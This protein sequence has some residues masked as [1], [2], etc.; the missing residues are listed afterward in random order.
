MTIADALENLRMCTEEFETADRICQT[1]SK[2][3]G[4]A[5]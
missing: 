3:H 5:V 1:W 2:V 4:F